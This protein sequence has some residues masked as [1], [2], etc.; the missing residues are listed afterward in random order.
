MAL[1]RSNFIGT[2][3]IS[4]VILTQDTVY[5][6]DKEGNLLKCLIVYFNIKITK[7]HLFCTINTKKN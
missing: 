6:N 2:V 3:L 5:G 4:V 7:C 1:N